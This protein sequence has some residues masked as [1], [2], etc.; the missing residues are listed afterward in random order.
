MIN[1]VFTLVSAVLG[2]AMFGLVLFAEASP[3]Q[4]GGG[5]VKADKSSDH[6][7]PASLMAI[8]DIRAAR[9]ATGGMSRVGYRALS[10]APTTQMAAQISTTGRLFRQM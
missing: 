2:L 8:D 7:R 4:A 1:I 10:A 6:S 9:T 3:A 5:D